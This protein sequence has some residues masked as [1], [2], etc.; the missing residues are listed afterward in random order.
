[1][2]QCKSSSVEG[3]ELGWEAVKDACRVHPLWVC[4]GNLDLAVSDCQMHQI[5]FTEADI[6][7]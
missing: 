6:G 7:L 1:M 4:S 5:N 2:I 3:R